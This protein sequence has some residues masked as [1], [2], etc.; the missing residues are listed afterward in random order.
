[1]LDDQT[2]LGFR[3]RADS[4]KAPGVEVTF[5]EHLQGGRST[6]RDDLD[7]TVLGFT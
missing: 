5:E 2:T 7:R 4:C 6:P 3:Y 1:M